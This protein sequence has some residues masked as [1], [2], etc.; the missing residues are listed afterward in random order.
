MNTVSSM[1]EDSI[2]EAVQ[3]IRPPKAGQ[4]GFYPSDESALKKLTDKYLERVNPPLI[5]DRIY[6][7]ICPHAG[8]IYSG[9]VAAYAYRLLAGRHYDTVI[10][11]GPSHYVEVPGAAVPDED[12]F[13]T[14][15]GNVR[16]NRQMISRLVEDVAGVE[17]ESRAHSEEHSIEVQLPLLQSVL[18]DFQIVPIVLGMPSFAFIKELARGLKKVLLG[19]DQVLL[20]ASTDLSH[21]HSYETASRLDRKTIDTV[22]S[23]DPETLYHSMNNGEVELCGAAG[24]MTLMETFADWG[25][26]NIELLRYQNSGDVTGDHSHVVGYG[27]FVIH[28]PVKQATARSDELSDEE[29]SLLLDIARKSIHSALSGQKPKYDILPE[30]RLNFKRG[31]FVT[32]KE[33]GELR[34]CIGYT[35]PLFPLAETVQRAAVAAA[36][37]DPRFEPVRADELDS[38]KIEISALTSL[39]QVNSIEEIE[40]GKHGLV[41]EKGMYKGLLLPQVAIE[42]GCNRKEFL[43]HTCIKAGLSPG[44]WSDPDTKIFLFSAEVFGEEQTH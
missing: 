22:L 43:D 21:Y 35:E 44:A 8:Y 34:G 9:E 40:I 42:Q 10:I 24:V 25:D 37:E 19:N 27:S 39:I 1:I 33:H 41:I 32:L 18:S 5:S 31:A 7:L 11:L 17:I 3:S 26:M 2:E 38:I 12:A 16:L 30:S 6:G 20:I 28:G 13:E 4:S 23:L 14:P 36:T 29:R 15:Y